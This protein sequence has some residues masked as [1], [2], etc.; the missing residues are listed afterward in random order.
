MKVKKTDNYII[1]F[2]MQIR[3]ILSFSP[4]WSLRIVDM[5][6]IIQFL[7]I[8]TYVGVNAQVH[9]TNPHEK[10]INALESR[11]RAV[12]AI[13]NDTSYDVNFYH[14][15]VFIAIDS[16]YIDGTVKYNMS[17]QKDNLSNIKLDLDSAF[18]VDNVGGAGSSFQF[19]HNVVTVD[20]NQT[21]NIGDTFSLWV[22]YHGVPVLAGGYKGL[23]YEKHHGNEPIIV[24][25]STPYLAHTWWPCKDGTSDKADSV[26]VDIT[27]K[28]TTVSSIPMVGVS[29]GLLSG[30]TA[31][32][33]MKTFSWKHRY[34]IVPYYVMVAISNYK[35]IE[36]TYSGN[37]YTMPL[38]YFVF[39]GDSIDSHQGVSDLPNV[40]SYFSDIF[41]EYPFKNEKYGM[42]QLGFYGGIENQTNSIVNN[43][44]TSSFDNLV[45]HEL[46]H[47]WFADN[48][49]CET[50][51]DA[52]LNEGF[53]SYAEALYKEH[54]SGFS[55]Y[56][57]YMVHFEDKSG[58]TLY[59]YDVSDP[60][61]V[62]NALIYSKGAYVLHMLRGVMGD[63]DF[64]TALKNYSTNPN[65]VY[66]HANTLD[67]QKVCENVSGRNLDYFF[68]QWIYD[69]YYPEYEYNFKNESNNIF[70]L[71]LNQVQSKKGRRD[72]F[73]MPIEIKLEFVDGSD[74]LISVMNS[75]VL[76]EYE[77]INMKQVQNINIDPN[78]WIL[79]DVR[80]NPNLVVG[81]PELN[82][83]DFQIYPNPSN[84]LIRVKI[85]TEFKS[86]YVEWNVYD[87]S[88]R[89]QL[90]IHQNVISG[91]VFSLDL[92]TLKSGMYFL[93]RETAN[94]IDRT[95]ITILK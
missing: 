23:R 43:M 93:Q 56:Q 15:D 79:K 76:Q 60:F 74:S 68:D 13:S 53:A 3:I 26:F 36:E 54:A 51:N 77:F 66:G 32:N 21:Y 87:I 24:S 41:G 20:L 55:S 35:L 69:A 49:T 10:L 62:F 2:F 67:F 83:S 50:W 65:Y 7:F 72:L 44:S 34:P 14:L 12:R 52:W 81:A 59:S 70:K 31:S 73:T 11:E 28:D 47:Q 22:K 29:N 42:T 37:G 18:T 19:D 80:L 84:G 58:G 90:T 57:N 91:S 86:Q 45:V 5:K 30:I 71:S 25:L 82:P 85:G 38:E 6:Y 61:A 4:V 17:A 48:I 92:S 89:L 88:G 27:I 9:R 46:A 63:T 39:A 95:P 64:F 16:S 8:L 78:K 40:I 33:G 75:H 94:K 1:G